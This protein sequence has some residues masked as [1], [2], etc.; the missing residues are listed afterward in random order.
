[1]LVCACGSNQKPETVVEPDLGPCSIAKLE[2]FDPGGKV[3]DRQIERVRRTGAFGRRERLIVTKCTD[4]EPEPECAERGRKAALAAYPDATV[5]MDMDHESQWVGSYDLDGK[6]VA[7]TYPTSDDM[8]A[9]LTK[10]KNKGKNVILLS[11]KQEPVEG[12]EVR[13]IAK[14]VLDSGVD[15]NA[16]ELRLTLVFEGQGPGAA[17]TMSERAAAE[18]LTVSRLQPHPDGTLVARISCTRTR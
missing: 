6:T 5:T 12:G 17:R 18:E 3:V 10:L 9:E 11:G 4:A 13:A 8:A 1:M 2:A 16:I 7:K 14:A 15:T